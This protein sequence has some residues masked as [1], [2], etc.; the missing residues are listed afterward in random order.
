[1]IN[2]EFDNKKH[3]IYPT[4]NSKH[5]NK[6]AFDKGFKDFQRGNYFDNPYPDYVILYKEWIRGQN[7]AYKMYQDRNK[8]REL[9]KRAMY[10]KI[11]TGLVEPKK[12]TYI[13]NDNLI[14]R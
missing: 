3:A 10:N 8:T 11:D 4:Y 6:K 13:T 5:L 12:F 2:N 1:M 14:G 7:A 9:Y